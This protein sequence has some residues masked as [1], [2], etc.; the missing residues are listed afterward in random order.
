MVDN[1]NAAVLKADWYDPDLNPKI[2]AF[3]EHYGTVILSTRPSTPRH[4]GK[5]AVR[6]R[7]TTQPTAGMQFTVLAPQSRPGVLDASLWAALFLTSAFSM[8]AMSACPG[9]SNLRRISR[10]A[11]HHC[12]ASAN[13]AWS[14]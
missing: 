14:S 2:Q 3:A 9:G 11:S 6:T 13:R 4:K 7:R 12:S 10:H 1:L 8:H 5:I